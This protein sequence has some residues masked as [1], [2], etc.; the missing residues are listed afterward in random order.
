MVDC[1]ALTPW[2]LIPFACVLQCLIISSTQAQH[3][4]MVKTSQGSIW[5]PKQSHQIK[6]SEIDNKES[7]TRVKREAE[8]YDLLSND[9][10]LYHLHL[11]QVPNIK[12][13]VI[14]SKSEILFRKAKAGQIDEKENIERKRKQSQSKPYDSKTSHENLSENGKYRMSK[15]LNDLYHD[16]KKVNALTHNTQDLH[17]SD[18]ADYLGQN[19]NEQ[20]Q[21]QEQ[22]TLNAQTSFDN[23]ELE[24]SEETQSMVE[25]IKSILLEE[26]HPLPL[27]DDINPEEKDHSDPAVELS[28]NKVS[29]YLLSSGKDTS[30]GLECVNKE[31]NN[32]FIN[33]IKSESSI[34]FMTELMNSGKLSNLLAE[35]QTFM[36]IQKQDN[37]IVNTIDISDRHSPIKKELEGNEKNLVSMRED[38]KY[39]SNDITDGLLNT[40]SE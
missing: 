15:S 30:E 34:N 13:P 10:E 17:S 4:D 40:D 27:N 38:K 39:L 24:L 14:A 3:W 32:N 7:F 23:E 18:L 5:S 31:L 28:E 19:D 9:D 20:E 35:L 37:S 1:P 11:H 21:Y 22:K 12:T 33:N 26:M 29:K 36:E 16:Y 25:I 8:S 6:G 2:F